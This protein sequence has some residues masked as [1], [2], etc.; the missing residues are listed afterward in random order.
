MPNSR[1]TSKMTMKVILCLVVLFLL[2]SCTSKTAQESNSLADRLAAADPARNMI[3]LDIPEITITDVVSG[4][5]LTTT[6]LKSKTVLI[7]SFIRG[8]PSCLEEIQK[9]NTLHKEYGDELLIIILDI[10]SRDTP[11]QLLEIKEQTEG[12]DYV[13]AISSEAAQALEMQGP[14]YTYIIKDGKIVYADSYVFSVEKLE[15]AVVEVL[16]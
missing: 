7:N 15:S 9:L 2:T 16:T 12:R 5:V 6:D 4:N 14:D 11:E 13:W 8:C 1:G 10:D 3:G